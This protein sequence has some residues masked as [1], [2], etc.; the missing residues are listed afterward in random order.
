M[1]K[2]S[3]WEISTQFAPSFKRLLLV[4]GLS[5][6]MLCLSAATLMAAGASA[7]TMKVSVRYDNATAKE[8][9]DEIERQTD[10]LFVYREELV[11]LSY[12]VSVRATN[13]PVNE[14]LDKLFADT[15]IGY[16]V[17]GDNI[18][19][20]SK[21]SLG[22]TPQSAQ[23]APDRVVR[24]VVTDGAGPIAGAAVSVKGGTQVAV[25]N[26]Q[27]AYSVTVPDGDAVLV[28]TFIGYVPQETIIGSREV[29]DV[30]LAVD[31]QMIDDVVVVGYG[32]I[33]KENLT[34]AVAQIKGEELEN[35]PVTFLAQALQG[36]VANLNISQSDGGGPGTSPSMNIRGYTGF[37]TMASPLVVIDGVQ[38][39]SANINS[40]NMNDVESISVLKDAASSAIY[41][42]SAAYGV[43]LIT[44]KKGGREKQPAI[45]YN[46]IFGFAQP[47]NI[48]KM[49]NSLDF[50]NTFNEAYVNAGMAP[51]YADFVIQ[52]IKDY[53]AG[54]IKDETFPHPVQGND[55]WASFQRT[56]ANND[57]FDIH[58]KNASFSQQH[59]VG[60]SGGS[61]RSSYYIGL[62]YND[63][64]GMFRYGTD[65]FKRYTVRANMAT[66]ITKWLTFSF[67]GNFARN[68]SDGPILDTWTIL[69][70]LTTAWP[71]VP[72]RSPDGYYAEFSQIPRLVDGGR[73]QQT[74]DRA[75]LTG[76]FVVKPL[77][78]WVITANYAIDMMSMARTDHL[79]TIYIGR[80]SGAK[81][82]MPNTS[83]NSIKKYANR[84]QRHVV[85]AFTYYEKNLGDHYFK[86]LVGFT[87]QSDDQWLFDASNTYLY[88]DSQPALSLSYNPTPS[89]S[90]QENQ[91]AVRAAFGRINY[92]YKEKYLVEFNGRYDGTS[93]F[94]KN[95]RMNFYPGV[96]A[97]WVPS[98]ESFWKPV[99]P[100]VDM[101]KIRASYA[102]LG[103]A[104]FNGNW[105]PFYP[106][107]GVTSP[108]GS[109]WLFNGGRQ[110]YVSAAGII[111]PDLT[112][113]TST[114]LDIGAD[115][116]FLNNRLNVSFD[117]YKRSS[118]DFVGPS[119]PLP[120]ILGANVPPSNNAAMET[121]GFDLSIGWRD[122]VFDNKFGYSVD[123]V[124]SDYKGKVVRYP[125][126]TGLNSTWYDGMSIGEIWGYETYGL[127]QSDE[128]IAAA[129]SQTIFFGN[130]TPGDVRYVDQNDDKKI[131]WGDNTVKNPGDRKIIGNSTPRYSF[132]LTLAADYKGF[133]L[134]V[135]MQGVGKRDSWIN[136]NM[137]WGIW[138]DEWRSSL[139]TIHEDRWTPENTGGYF[140]KYYI[141]GGNQSKNYQTQTRYLQNSAYMRIKNLQLGYSLPQSLI[142]KIN[143]SKV[144]VFVS[145]ENLATFTRMF[146]TIDPEFSASDGK[147]YP[148]QRNWAFGLNITF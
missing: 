92:N 54:L 139:F 56:H 79:K 49:M 26:A 88:S 115:L 46:N 113:S 109:S 129:P 106:S 8:V 142:G 69:H 63:K 96:S 50:A 87:Q 70:N 64:D 84:T 51:I 127:F 131:D 38:Q 67:M 75:H 138:Q 121:T 40:I 91:L 21:A 23:Q 118:K 16:A 107:M 119:E 72:L 57:W 68:V 30:S 5:T 6:T 22:Q 133:D 44:T 15:S 134:S 73:L 101:L 97:A 3:L 98:K 62:G 128:E 1:K 58:F 24:G 48:P 120:A 105:Y 77:P 14:V 122:R 99:R 20:S 147:I 100:F 41:G 80:P 136:N 29:I 32:S 130:W 39:G 116:A 65:S 37:G 140:P 148:L 85:N 123:L 94:L 74:S 117:W 89:V 10:Y 145:V 143:F 27:G 13:R 35:R 36:Q 18:L 25:T 7:Q 125:N 135:F 59:N 111:N 90:D 86:V 108:T 126:P 60:V 53:Q 112:W 2:K 55:V 4:M 124:L 103:D 102:S 43:I 45:S 81:F 95:R 47:I 28:F 42:S 78:G 11:D 19:L 114:T 76:E 82:L 93:R 83:P 110:A 34:G 144:R 31:S 61:E 71:T 132:G 33:R 141:T 12:N 104:D 9:V 137:F 52:N 17:Q 66:D 146:K